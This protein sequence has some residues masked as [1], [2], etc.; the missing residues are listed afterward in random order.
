MSAKFLRSRWT[1]FER[2][3][4]SCRYHHIRIDCT[5]PSIMMAM[6]TVSARNPAGLRRSFSCS[7]PISIR[8]ARSVFAC[9]VGEQLAMSRLCY[10]TRQP[11]P[12]RCDTIH[13]HL[14][15]QSDLSARLSPRR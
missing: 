14:V 6:T 11:H 3:V 9:L 7:C 15:N 5:H 8:T 4:W 12:A 13:S 2:L 10:F 1:L